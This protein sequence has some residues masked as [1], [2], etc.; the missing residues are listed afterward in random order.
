VTS[1]ANS[2]YMLLLTE[3]HRAR[4]L[5]PKAPMTVMAAMEMRPATMAYSITSPPASS[6]ARI[7][8]DRITRDISLSPS[9]GSDRPRRPPKSAI[10]QHFFG[11]NVS[12]LNNVGGP[13][14]NRKTPGSSGYHIIA[15]E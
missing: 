1:A 13:N 14:K 5:A 7:V 3:F 11:Q 15:G 10:F 8:R 6:F 4:T 9:K 12:R 2:R